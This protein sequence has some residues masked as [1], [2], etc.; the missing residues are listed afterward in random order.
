MKIRLYSWILLTVVGGSI[1]LADT[2]RYSYDDAGRLVSAAYANGNVISYTYDKAGNLLSRVV[3]SGAG[4]VISAMVNA[5]SFSAGGIVPG[6]IATIFGTNL[7]SDTGIN[8]TSGLPLPTTFLKVSVIVN[9]SPAP[10]FAIDNVN[11]QQ[12]INFQVPWEVAGRP[13]AMVAVANNGGTGPAVAVPVLAAQPGIISYSAGGNNFGLILHADFQL[14]D[15]GHPVV[16]GETVLIYCTGM[17]AVSSTPP[18]GSAASGQ[19][20]TAKPSVTIGGAKGGVSFSGLAP[21]FVGLNQVNV[22]VPPGTKSGN[23][24]V[25][26]TISGVSSNSVLLPVQ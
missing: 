9:G 22:Q 15:T 14:A 19:P 12:Q 6:E 4:P 5:A 2:V 8:L 25:V 11:G 7:T 3:G 20:T 1:V 16:A 24:A 21:G 26:I 17:G 18:D 10:L 23:Q 13:N